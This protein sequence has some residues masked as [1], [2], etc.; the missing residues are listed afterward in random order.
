MTTLAPALTELTFRED[1]CLGPHGE[2]CRGAE[3]S[4]GRKTG[5]RVRRGYPLFLQGHQSS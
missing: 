3:E 5:V 2:G 1:K 4:R